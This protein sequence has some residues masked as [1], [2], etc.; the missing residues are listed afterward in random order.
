[1]STVEI[2]PLG[3]AGEIGRNCTLV[4][5]GD[6]LI[7]V[8]CGISFAHEELPGVRFV[9]PDFQYLRDNK[10]KVKG[11]FLTHA[12][13]DHIG[14]VTFLLDY[15]P[16][17]PIYAT[18]FTHAMLARKLSERFDLKKLILRTV[19][20]G[21]VEKAG[22]FEVEYVPITHSI[23]N[24]SAVAIRTSHG[25]VLF[26]SDF[27]LDFTP[28]DQ[29]LT[30]IDRLIELG[31]EGIV[32]LLSDCTNVD[33]PGWSPSEKAV[34][35]GFR[36]AFARAEGRILITQFA[37]NIHR[38]QQAMEVAAETGRKVAVAGR[39]MEET[40]ELCTKMG[41]M[42]PPRGVR[43]RLDQTQDFPPNE[44]VILCTGSQGEPRSA[45]VQ[46]SKND[47][48]RLRVMEGDTIL[49][50]ARPIPG[51]EGAIWRTVNRLFELGATVVYDAD[52]TIH[53]SGHGYQEELKMM[54]NLTKPFYLAPVHGEPRHQYLY[55]NL[56]LEMGHSD[57]RIFELKDGQKL[58]I[59]DTQAWTENV[60]SGDPVYLDMA[61]MHV[62]ETSIIREKAAMAEHGLAVLTFFIQNGALQSD[63]TI[64]ARGFTGP[65]EVLEKAA[66]VAGDHVR[67][68]SKADLNDVAIIRD[69]ARAAAGSVI[70]RSTQLRPVLV[71]SIVK[72]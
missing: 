64:E 35:D 53:V 67:N 29:K 68:L 25:V 50:S 33:R 31:K 51:N 42:K 65:T 38:M 63:P 37:S 14:A 58:V 8:D 6:D 41:L 28:V 52:P 45:L 7:I 61:D 47:Y 60:V 22:A 4:Q 39:R 46:M 3:G 34:T 9:I 59:D 23:P 30:Q 48:T 71:V 40:I 72:A 70:A 36:A 24:N 15:L 12:H 21:E 2:L 43:I 10:E 20:P 54:I 11:L 17:I 27:K 57:H 13:E 18:E 1:M 32:A 44:V 19:K 56:A 26:T 16:K 66:K 49:Y 69:T 62:V 5:Q 55:R